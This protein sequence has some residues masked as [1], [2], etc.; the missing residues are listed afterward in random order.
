MTVSAV[1]G[2]RA[3]AGAIAHPAAPIPTSVPLAVAHSPVAGGRADRPSDPHVPSPRFCAPLA[4][5]R[6]K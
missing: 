3:V 4:D 1:P 2:A 6:A 5:L